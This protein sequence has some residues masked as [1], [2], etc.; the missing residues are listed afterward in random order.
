MNGVL[1]DRELLER[2]IAPEV[3][4][5][6]NPE[7]FFYCRHCDAHW[8][9]KT[10]GEEYHARGCPVP[11]LRAALALPTQPQALTAEVWVHDSEHAELLSVTGCVSVHVWED[12]KTDLTENSPELPEGAYIVPVDRDNTDPT[13]MASG[14]YTYYLDWKRAVPDRALEVQG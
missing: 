2:L 7:D 9:N 1:V 3:T 14:A 13:G 5:G 10:E 11:A 6:Q 4:T 12:L 8:T